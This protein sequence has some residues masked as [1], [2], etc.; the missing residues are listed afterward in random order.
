VSIKG[1]WKQKTKAPL[2]SL[3]VLSLVRDELVRNELKRE[4]GN[5]KAR[6]SNDG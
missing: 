1:F 5:E 3:N 4:R 2:L 6:I